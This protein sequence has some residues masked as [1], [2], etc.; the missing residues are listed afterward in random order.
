MGRST[1]PNEEEQEMLIERWS[2]GFSAITSD[3]LLE[4]DEGS[5]W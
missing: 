3:V 1:T 2:D 4:P 5:W